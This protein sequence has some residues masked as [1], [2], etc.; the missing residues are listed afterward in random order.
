MFRGGIG[1]S[2]LNSLSRMLLVERTIDDDSGQTTDWDSDAY[3]E[4]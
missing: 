3:G 1:Q 2:V 4:K